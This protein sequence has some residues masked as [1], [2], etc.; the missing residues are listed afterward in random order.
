MVDLL[1]T[2]AERELVRVLIVDGNRDFAENLAELGRMNGLAPVLCDTCAGARARIR[3]DVFDVA[4]VEQRLPDGLGID[5]LADLR[6]SC[7][8][9]VLIVVTAFVSLDDT[10]AALNQGA[11][12]FLAKDSDPDELLAII[13]RA[14]ENA[15]LRRENRGLRD[16]REAILRALPDQLLLV[17]EATRIVSVNQRHPAF[18]PCD[19]PAAIGQPLLDV[20]APFLRERLELGELLQEA[21]AKKGEVKRTVE[22]RDDSGRPWILGLSAIPLQTLESPL[23]L[24]RVVDLTDRIAL[25][26]QLTD[27][28]H[29]ATL[30]RLVSSIAHEVRNPLAGIRALAQLL[31]RRFKDS[32]ND[33]ES[34]T[35][36]LGLT[37]R[38]HATLSDLLDFARPGGH[39][40][41]TIELAELCESLIAQAQ[42]WPAA[43]ER[44]LE[45][46][47]RGDRPLHVLAARDRVF[48]AV[49]NLVQ[50]ALQAVPARGVVRVTLADS[51]R[52]CELTVEDS[53]PGI[54]AEV[55]PRLFQPFFTTKTR[56][57]GL[58]LSIVKKTVEMLGGSIAVDRS[59]ELGGARF[60]L[61]LPASVA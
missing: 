55:L 33:L 18:C 36:I 40:D 27:A 12:A 60:K 6:A 32:P 4:I 31:Q 47:R 57:T 51:P 43:H 19:P 44:R 8:D 24:L 48:G 22:V 30:G 21:S 1:A 41:E 49:E 39:R 58:G 56:G 34:A 61:N 2:A 28:Q 54:P 38:M 37:D 46:V 7:P 29:L 25:E 26:R 13:A 11:F 10:L 3:S 14:A 50:N 59:K 52:G 23:T 9:I 35:E 17:D 53:G 42:R 20:V 16:L 15:K 5:L 45:Y